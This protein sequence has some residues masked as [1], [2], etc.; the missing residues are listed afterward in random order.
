MSDTPLHLPLRRRGGVVMLGAALALAALFALL[1][2][3]APAAALM[4]GWLVAFAIA[5]SVPIGA[6]LW[7]MIHALTGGAWGDAAAPVLR[8]AAAAM[9]VV[10]LAFLPV[11]AGS[12]AI[13]PW[14][15]M[16]ASVPADVA[17]WYLNPLSFAL[18]AVIALTGWSLL[19]GLFAAGARSQLL[20]ALGL[21]FFGLSIS[22]V[23]VDWYLSLQPRYT[24]S[25]F[26]ATIAIQ[27]LLM[28]MAL[29]AALVPG[30]AGRTA[31]DL[32]ALLLAALLG[33]VYLEF[34]SFVIAWYG[35]LPD[36]P[37]WF[38][39]RSGGAWVTV[40]LVALVAGALLPFALLLPARGRESG[41][42][43]RVAGVLIL[44]GSALHMAWLLL[45]AFDDPAASAAVACT[46]L[47]AM[48]LIAWQAMR[49]READHAA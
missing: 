20:A 6:M 48:G 12:H 34:M 21:A 36:K 46:A 18:R 11:L 29:A 19:G 8:P 44:L 41:A 32:G 4:R 23:A 14:A 43:L 30:L 42:T 2:I 47:A 45:P 33:V 3:V 38:L 24:S 17:A 26:A 7:L 28:A 37:A 1:A 10:A 35:N 40:L 31:G 13:Y 9:P 5:G 15:A 49:W 25:A 27:Q 22:L 16:P 39:A